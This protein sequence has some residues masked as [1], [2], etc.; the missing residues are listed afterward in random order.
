MIYL[1][2]IQLPLNLTYMYVLNKWSSEMSL[3]IDVIDLDDYNVLI[4]E[5]YAY[6]QLKDS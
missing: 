2:L 4:C 3:I 6:L 1:P 5:A